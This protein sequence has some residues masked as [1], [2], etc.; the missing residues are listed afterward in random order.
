MKSICNVLLFNF[1]ILTII[2]LICILILI[3]SNYDKKT[4]MQTCGTIYT[5]VLVISLIRYYY[6]KDQKQTFCEFIGGFNGGVNEE[7][8]EGIEEDSSLLATVI[9]PFKNIFNFASS[10][11]MAAITTATAAITTA[12][13][14]INT[15]IGKKT[16]NEKTDKEKINDEKNIIIDDDEDIIN[17]MYLYPELLHS[18]KSFTNQLIP[19]VSSSKPISSNKIDLFTKKFIINK[20]RI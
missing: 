1:Y 14:T 9:S 19:R 15:A 11:V 7:F 20:K 2:C 18:G 8:N 6:V 13:A 5:F 3:T 16:T 10:T 4:V 17:E 12:T